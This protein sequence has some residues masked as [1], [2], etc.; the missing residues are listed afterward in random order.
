MMCQSIRGKLLGEVGD[1]DCTGRK[2]TFAVVD[3]ISGDVGHIIHTRSFGIF[4]VGIEYG[5]PGEI[6]GCVALS[7][8]VGVQAHLIEVDVASILVV[9]LRK[10]NIGGRSIGMG[11]ECKHHHC[12]F[13][14]A[15][16]LREF[17]IL[18]IFIG[19]VNVEHS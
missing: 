1:V 2:L 12:R 17:T 6:A 11:E 9:E 4:T 15:N 19:E 16:K 8:L 13:A 3:I 10:L 5:N 7:I 18:A 14:V